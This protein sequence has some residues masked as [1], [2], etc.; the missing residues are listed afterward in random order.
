MPY[1]I[2]EKGSYGC[3]GY[4]VVKDGTAEIMGCHETTAQA[5][6]QISAINMGESEGSGK[7]MTSAVGQPYPADTRESFFNWSTPIRK[8]QRSTFSIGK[9]DEDT[10]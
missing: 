1:H 5:Q 3:Q 9:K 10:L 6:S 2:G 7:K 8:P 4:P